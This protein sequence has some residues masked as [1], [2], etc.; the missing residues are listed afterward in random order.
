MLRRNFPAERY[1]G[2]AIQ[3]ASIEPLISKLMEIFPSDL[4]DMDNL[5]SELSFKSESDLAAELELPQ[6]QQAVPA[7][8]PF[9]LK[10]SL[11]TDTSSPRG[12]CGK[13]TVVMMR[14]V[15]TLALR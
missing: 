5:L 10:K 8:P 12:Y 14:R 2:V 1:S 6:S 3:L 15:T 4:K 11:R 7:E 13:L 9:F